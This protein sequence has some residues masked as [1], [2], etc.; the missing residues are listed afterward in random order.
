[1]Y[2]QENLNLGSQGNGEDW[3]LIITG[4]ERGYVW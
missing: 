1:M 4:T 3:I 2:E